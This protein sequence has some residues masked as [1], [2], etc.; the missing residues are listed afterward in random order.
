VPPTG[1]TATTGLAGASG[2][3][4][5]TAPAAPTL[6]GPLAEILADGLAAAPADTAPVVRAEIAAGNH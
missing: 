5:S 6:P 3:T 4:G 2:P 1:P